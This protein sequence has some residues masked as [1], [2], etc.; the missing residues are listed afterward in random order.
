LSEFR[1]RLLEEEG[2]AER[3]LLEEQTLAECKDR[4]L[5]KT[6][7]KQRTDSTHVLAAVKASG[8][9]ECIGEMMRAALNVLATVAPGWL[10]R[11]APPEWY[12]RYGP[13]VE[14]YRLPKV[15]AERKELAEQI[16]SDGLRL[17]AAVEADDALARLRDLDAMCTLERLWAEQYHLPEKPGGLV[18]LREPK[19]M[20]PAAQTLQSPYDTE[21][22]YSWTREVNRIGYKV[23]LTETC[24]PEGPNL[25][26]DVKT[27]AATVPDLKVLGA[28]HASLEKR[29]LLPNEHL[30]D[31]GYMGSKEMADSLVHYGV[32]LFGPMP[33]DGSWQAKAGE[34]FD[35]LA[36]RVDWEAK[37]VTCPEGK[38][39]KQWKPALNRHGRDVVAAIFDKK[40]C[41]A[42]PSRPL[43]TRSKTTGRELTLRPRPLHEALR[44]ARRRQ[45]TREFWEDYHARAGVEGTISQGVR[46][47][48]LRRSRY[49]GMAK[50]HLQ[51]VIT[52]L[53]MNAGPRNGHSRPRPRRSPPSDACAARAVTVSPGKTPSTPAETSSPPL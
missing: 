25:I 41:A 31:S 9:L 22:R 5:L 6:R 27:T 21:A 38:K 3:L 10:T 53:A 1:S 18:R 48:G 28:V 33:R 15:D 35:A 34:G 32:D 51:H 52:A 23:H 43:C 24:D 12:E 19:E 40:E 7:G 29:D 30:V 44:K 45:E 49:V 37:W 46:E 26:T 50:T 11:W 16:G 14:E 2:R 47:C 17:L 4:G 39:S 42:C 20:P 8:R 13:R 36:F